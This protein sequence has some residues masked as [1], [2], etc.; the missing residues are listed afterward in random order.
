ME[1][2]LYKDILS[3]TGWLGEVVSNDDPDFDGKIKVRVFGHDIDEP[4]L[5]I[6]V[7]VR[8]SIIAQGFSSAKLAALFYGLSK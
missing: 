7:Q 3:N 6:M 1:N 5:L 2:N 4:E 8:N